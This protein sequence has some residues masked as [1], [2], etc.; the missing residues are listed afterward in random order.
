MTPASPQKLVGVRALVTRPRERAAELCF[1]LEDEGA[2]VVCLPLLE[3][4]PPKDGR[5]LRAAAEVVHRY[6]WVAFASPSAVEAV[7]EA[8]REAG[9]SQHLFGPGCK[10]AVVGPGTGRVAQANGL[11]VTVEA[12]E[13]SGKGLLEALTPHVKPDDE[14]LLPAAEEG[15][16]ELEEGLGALGARVTRVAAYASAPIDADP[17]LVSELSARPPEVVFVGSP[18]TAEALLELGRNHPRVLEHARLVAIGPTT[19]EGLAAL[20]R[21]AA[22]VA[23]AATAE[24]MVDAALSVFPTKW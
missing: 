22:A 16:R 10:I 23:K 6:S 14:I 19:A 7:V 17:L 18:R 12:R 8:C 13:S 11:F 3:L 20:G 21:P 4:L 9:T 5:P 24:A 2:E 1:L 15:R